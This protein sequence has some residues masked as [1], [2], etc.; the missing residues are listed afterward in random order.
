MSWLG[1]HRGEAPLLI[2][3]PHTGTEIP[4]EVESRMISPWL[5]RKD[6]DWYVDLLYAMAFD[7]GVTMVRTAISRTVIDVNR[8]PSGASLYPGQATTGLCPLTSFDGEPLYQPDAEPDKAEIARRRDSYFDPYHAAIGAELDRLQKLHG[9]V[10]LYD[11]HSIR[12]RIPR[13]FDGVLPQFNIGNNRGAT[14]DPALTEAV[15][16]AC[17]ASP[18]SMVTNGRFVGGWT[19][20]HYGKP[21]SGIHAIQMELAQRG[22][23]DEPPLCDE[24]NWPPA[25][26]PERAARLIAVL[27]TVIQNCI[28]FAATRPQ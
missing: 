14:C 24:G 19:T 9:K 7:L 1:I 15:E 25:Y 10:V 8:D 13:L 22:Y 28:A 2:A 3:M 4:P 17:S 26:H 27:K 16:S 12:S 23:L 5:A 11:A 20:R 21:E 6:A 18:F